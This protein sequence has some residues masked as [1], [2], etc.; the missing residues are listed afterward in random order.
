MSVTVYDLKQRARKALP[1]FQQ[2][3]GEPGHPSLTEADVARQK[4][5]YPRW[6]LRIEEAARSETDAAWDEDD[7]YGLVAETLRDLIEYGDH[8]W[9]EEGLTV[10]EIVD[11]VA[12]DFSLPTL[13]MELYEWARHSP[14][15]SDIAHE[16][17]DDLADDGDRQLEL[18]QEAMG[19]DV[20]FLRRTV[21]STLLEQIRAQDVETEASG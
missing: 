11:Q 20:F 6:L 8:R 16:L 17:R 2:A 21:L 5:N 3:L 10:E 13:N 9:D 1:Y 12:T 7:F 15:W 19:E 14:D 18:I 4:E